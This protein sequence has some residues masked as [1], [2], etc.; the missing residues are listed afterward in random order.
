MRFSDWLLLK[1]KAQEDAFFGHLRI[2]LPFFG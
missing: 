1:I 2:C